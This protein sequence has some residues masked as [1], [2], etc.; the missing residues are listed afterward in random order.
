V[1]EGHR[2]RVLLDTLPDGRTQPL[3]VSIFSER[4]MREPS[5]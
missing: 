5:P 3:R 2:I 4:A 1:I